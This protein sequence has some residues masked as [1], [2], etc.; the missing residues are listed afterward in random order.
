M[1]F[2]G[3]TKL[4][5][6]PAFD[7]DPVQIYEPKADESPVP[8][9]DRD[10]VPPPPDG[11]EAS[12]DAGDE[13][14]GT[15]GAGGRRRGKYYVDD[16]EVSVVSERVQYLDGGDL[17]LGLVNVSSAV[18]VSEDIAKTVGS[19]FWIPEDALLIAMSGAT[20][21]KVAFNKTGRKLLLNQRVGRLEPIL[22]RTEYVR[23]FFETIVARNLSISFG[24]AIPNLSAE[25]INGTLLP[26]PPLA[27]QKRIVAKV[28]ELMALCDRLEAQQQERETQHA[29][30]ARA[31]LARFADAPSPANL[32]CIFH[33]SYDIAPADL[34]KTI[35]TLAVQGKLVPQDPNDE[36]AETLNSNLL[37]QLRAIAESV[38]VRFSVPTA[39]IETGDGLPAGWGVAAVQSIGI[40][41]TGT[42]PSKSDPS[43]TGHDIPFIK[44]G[45]IQGD[46]VEY[47]NEGLS[48][49]GLGA[50]RSIPKNSVLMVSIGGSIGKTAIVDRDV[51]CN[52]QINSVSPCRVHRTSIHSHGHQI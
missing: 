29:A 7:G 32:N 20:T 23:F 13:N 8:P 47:E 9:A 45:D 12:E 36:S 24:S 41:Q 6:D 52:Q 42:T 15:L 44:P 49:N 37:N 51:S 10:E 33:K 40:T 11:A 5:A 21:G 2:R 16:V 18:C 17:Q 35:L 1:D 3:A 50:G 25:Q 4:F 26:L 48:M 43:F 39:L 27:E 30:L 19:E 34:R 28:D 46:E 14:G 38:G 22:V 31:S